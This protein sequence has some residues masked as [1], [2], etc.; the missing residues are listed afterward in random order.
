MPSRSL[1]A[2]ELGQAEIQKALT[3]KGWSREGLA[4]EAAVSRATAINFCTGKKI[5]RK[6]F[7]RFCELLELDWEIIAGFKAADDPIPASQSAEAVD[8]DVLVQQVRSYLQ[9]DVKKRCGWMKVLNMTYPIETSAIYTD[10]NLLGKPLHLRSFRELERSL[11][12]FDSENFDRLWLGQAIEDQRRDGIET[13]QDTNLLMILGAPGAGKSTFLKRLAMLCYGEDAAHFQAL[14]P[15]FVTLKE[16]AEAEGQP[17]LLNYLASLG[18]AAVGA[19][20][21][22]TI[23]KA[24][25]GLVLLDGLDE[26]LERDRDCTID[27][28]R[29][30]ADTYDRNHIIITCR[31]AAREYTFTRFT[32]VEIA[33]FNTEQIAD[34]AYK[35]F[36]AKE[37]E[38]TAG[39]FLSALEERPP[40]KEL[41]TNPLL[42]TL[43]CLEFEID[44]AFPSSRAELYERGL[45]VLFTRWDT[46]RKIKR[47]EVYKKLPVKR[48]KELLGQLGYAMFD[49]GEYLFKQR[50]AEEQI[51]GYI[52]NLP[53]AQTDPEALLVDSRAVLKSIESQ[54]GLLTERASHIYSFSHLTFQEY[55][56]AQQ[57]VQVQSL[58]DPQGAIDRLLDHLDEPRWKEVF[59]LVV[60]Q[61]PSADYLLKQMKQKIDELLVGDE[62]L[63]Q[64]LKWVQQKSE[65]VEVLYKPA[66]VRAFYFDLDITRDLDLDLAH[67]LDLVLAL[68]LTRT[69]DRTLDLDLDLNLDFD[70]THDLDLTRARAR[71]FARAFVRGRRIAPS[72]DLD[73]AR[74]LAYDLDL[75]L[76][77]DRDDELKRT[78]QQLRDELPETSEKKQYQIKKW[79][80]ANGEQWTKRLRQVTMERRNIGHDWQF[81]ESEI[82]RLN[83][84]YKANKL[85][86]ECL[87]SECYV[88]RSLREEIESTL[89]LPIAS[90]STVD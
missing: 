39:D 8:L 14:M 16:F 58:Q 72:L 13:V 52:A 21:I 75:A 38:E 32:D 23:L 10:V 74:A 11:P 59:F 30:F 42:L 71:A 63:Q 37:D 3:T 57:I 4:K 84:Y 67:N 69:I 7:V 6:N 88:S 5:D 65:S 55:F 2:S 1:A 12:E 85:L 83:Q 47:E 89:L 56:T 34:F 54:H 76:D 78:L 44:R 61:L 49:R 80:K 66:A 19:E 51:S 20:T 25:R 64:F 73:L 9:A 86:V 33:S 68:A 36:C 87:N 46:S 26:V 15:F 50:L 90:L 29:T 48:K 81:T 53:D 41:A 82:Q 24:N 70:L 31:I 45:E 77:R 17:N 40:I 62:K 35:W 27:Q 60:E 79:W 28:I 43:L 22:A 18:N